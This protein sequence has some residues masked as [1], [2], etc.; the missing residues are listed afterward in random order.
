M[1]EVHQL[2]FVSSRVAGWAGLLALTAALLAGL[3]M[4]P[5]R[6][7]EESEKFTDEFRL[8][9]CQWSSTGKNTYFVL[10][11]KYQLVF[12]GREGGKE[13]G[14]T[15]T[16][17]NQTKQVNGVQ[18]RVVEERHTEDGELI[19]L[20]RNWFA[21]CK[22]TNSAFYF[23]EDVDNIEDGQVVNHDG[24]WEA[25]KNGAKP[26]LI[27][28]GLPLLGA[29]YFQELAPGAALDRAEIESLNATVR[30]PAGTFNGC[31]KTEETTP[32]EPK[33]EDIKFYAPGIGLVQ[34]GPLKLVKY[35]FI[36]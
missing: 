21:I 2:S 15:I 19:E 31:L 14:L 3:A 17:L 36:P 13:V 10:E 35:G 30:T 12:K 4:P 18:T 25:G 11:P 16:V 7:A 27:M 22:Q 23:G 8:G 34:D 29:R 1:L 33:A 26:G 6:A 32:L 28:P 24:S 9:D 5:A 20:S